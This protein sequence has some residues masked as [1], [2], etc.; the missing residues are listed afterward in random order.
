MSSKRLFSIVIVALALCWAREVH[1][2]GLSEDEKEE[3]LEAHNYFRGQVDPVA[4][5]MLRMEW[6][7]DLAFLAQYRAA[8]C[9][10]RQEDNQNNNNQQQ[11][12]TGGF[13]FVGE[14]SAAT[15]FYTGDVN[16]TRLIGQQWFIEKRFFSYYAAACLDEDGNIEDNGEFMTCGRYTQL[17]W[18]RSYA[19]GC[20]SYKCQE[21]EGSEDINENALLLVC[22]YGPGGN[23]IAEPPYTTGSKPCEACPYDRSY[24]T[25]NLCSYSG[26]PPVVGPA[27]V[28]ALVVVA[29]GVLR[30]SLL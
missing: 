8:S 26:A 25:K 12:Q 18:A 17:V 9:E 29:L 22:A 11:V 24:C 6:N 27:S 28:V 21:L 10:F 3:I 5:N 30:S 13:D 1:G 16:Y 19:V 20:G 14:N 2:Q 15:S 4:T 23:F 7:E